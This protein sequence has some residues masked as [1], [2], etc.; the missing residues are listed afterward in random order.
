MHMDL[1]TRGRLSPDITGDGYAGTLRR[2]F[3]IAVNQFLVVEGEAQ[4]R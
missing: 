2:G 1:G 3:T 4:L